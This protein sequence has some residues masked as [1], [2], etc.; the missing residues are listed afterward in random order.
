MKYK[1]LGNSNIEISSMGLGCMGMSFAYG[2]PDDKESILTLERSLELG[3]N[4]WDT[5]DVYGNGQNE[6][7]ISKVLVNNRDK[8][9]LATKFGFRM[10]NAKTNEMY[11]D[12]SKKHIKEA[13]E[14][15]LKR[16]KIDV[17]DLYYM[18]RVDPNTPFDESVNAM[19]ELVIEGNVKFLVI[20]DCTADDLQKSISIHS[21]SALQSEY[22][23]LT[24]DVEKEMLP[25]TKKLGITFVAFSPLIRGFISD[26]L[27]VKSLDDTDMRKTLPR[28]QDEYLENNKMLSEEFSKFASS[29]NC[30]SAQ[31]AI[32]WV[33]AQS[34]NIV[35]I[36]G[37]KKRKYLEE[38]TKAVDVV[39]TSKDLEAIGDIIKKYP[40]VGPRYG[41]KQQ[42]F[43]KQNQK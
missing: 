41:A 14:D 19:S 16:L 17:I 39:L 3:I 37:T 18:H 1:K 21:I 30:T 33:M 27:D 36:P 34:E 31:L 5:A 9:V 40:N 13:V 12:C 43:L 25:L 4:F 24:K 26:A 15:S 20:S 38:N 2:T 8:I 35:P 11:L 28:F 29:K 23:L 7:L 32:A 6:E 42:Q 22:S 10:K